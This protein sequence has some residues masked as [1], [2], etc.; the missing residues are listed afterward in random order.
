MYYYVCN[1]I[2]YNNIFNHEIYWEGGGVQ[3]ANWGT[4]SNFLFLL[5]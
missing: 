3:L 5:W 1:N 2:K 4:F